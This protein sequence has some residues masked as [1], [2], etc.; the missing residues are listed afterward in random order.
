MIHFSNYFQNALTEDTLMVLCASNQF[1]Q[2]LFGCDKAVKYCRMPIIE[3]IPSSKIH[4]E[5]RALTA[6]GTLIRD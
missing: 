3:T 4:P 2:V 5:K 6:K 1:S